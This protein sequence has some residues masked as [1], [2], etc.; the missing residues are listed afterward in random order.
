MVALLNIGSSPSSPGTLLV[1]T[2]REIAY[3]LAK[4]RN[5]N[6]LLYSGQMIC[7]KIKI[8]VS[9]IKTVVIGRALYLKVSFWTHTNSSNISYSPR[10]NIFQ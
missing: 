6:D 3:R 1:S 4:T 10:V 9:T 5:E 8:T 2:D 7:S